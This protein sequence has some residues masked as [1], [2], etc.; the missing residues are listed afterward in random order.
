MTFAE[1][2]FKLRR[3]AGLS[4][5]E[6][7]EKLDVSR[8]AISRWE[9]GIAIPDAANLLQLSRLF[10][11]TVDYLIKDELSSD[12]DIPLVK[13]KQ[14]DICKETKKLP[15]MLNAVWM[16]TA[17]AVTL[18][19]LLFWLTVDL[20]VTV[21]PMLTLPFPVFY[22]FALHRE[23]ASARSVLFSGAILLLAVN[24]ITVAGYLISVRL[25]YDESYAEF[26]LWS[27][28]AGFR[29]FDIVCCL[30]AVALIS[31]G[32]SMAFMPMAKKWWAGL[33]V[34]ACACGLSGI[35][36]LLYF[37]FTADIQ[38][39]LAVPGIFLAV[40]ILVCLLVCMTYLLL[41]KRSD[42]HEKV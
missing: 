15:V 31:F 42:V 13:S 25:H 2:V 9:M 34:Y 18:S 20:P 29:W 23:L 35:V 4:Q 17:I 12:E 10:D 39:T 14:A 26:V 21:I 36:L 38:N 30:N 40:S 32:S 3:K 1:K 27:F 37:T 7:A 19:V 16:G 28:W 41:K 22:Y 6:L 5:E 24:L 33:L 11:V 8:Q